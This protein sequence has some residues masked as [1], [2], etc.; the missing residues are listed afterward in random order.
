MQEV[1]KNSIPSEG[2]FGEKERTVYLQFF[3]NYPS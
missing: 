1:V 3:Q 2:S